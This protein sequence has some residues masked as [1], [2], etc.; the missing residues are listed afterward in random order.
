MRAAIRWGGLVA[1]AS[2]NL[3]GAA[4]GGGAGSTVRKDHGFGIIYKLTKPASGSTWTKLT[5]YIFIS[6]PAARAAS[7]S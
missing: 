2:G 7:V 4:F 1:D 6:S 3:Y 5:L